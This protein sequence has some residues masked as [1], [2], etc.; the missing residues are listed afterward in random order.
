M[1]KFICEG[2]LSRV[3]AFRLEDLPGNER[4]AQ[5]AFINLPTIFPGTQGVSTRRSGMFD[6]V[7][8]ILYGGFSCVRTI[9]FQ[10]K[11]CRQQIIGF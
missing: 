5:N 9:L 6:A 7:A 1:T 3:S 10:R 11:K 8:G 2:E 4:A